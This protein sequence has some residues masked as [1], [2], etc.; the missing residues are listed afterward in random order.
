MWKW[1]KVKSRSRVRLFA[2]PWTACSPPGSSVHGILQ[3]RILEW[4]AISFSRDLP[5]PGIEPRSSALQA[6]TLTSEPPG[7]AWYMWISLQFKKRKLKPTPYAF[8][9][10]VKGPS[11]GC[12]VLSRQFTP[13]SKSFQCASDIVFNNK[14][15]SSSSNFYP[16]T[17]NVKSWTL[18][19]I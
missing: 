7:K 10:V 14:Q 3:A 15:E 5:D 8:H 18:I 1:K 6:D 11:S 17:V 4:V 13:P 9:H 12:R 16:S 19:I 2:T